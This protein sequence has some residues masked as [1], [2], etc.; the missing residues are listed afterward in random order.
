[1][2]LVET[3]KGNPRLKKWVHR[4]LVRSREARP[5]IWVKWFVN[6][7]VHQ[8]GRSTIIRW[9]ARM[10]VLPFNAF[11]LGDRSIIEDLCTVNNGSGPVEIGHDTMVGI[12]SVLIGPVQIGSKVIIAQHVVM[13]GLNHIYED[14]DQPIVDQ[15]VRTAPIIIEDE[16]WIGANA[17]I[18]AGVTIGKHAVV[19]GGA[20][21]TKNVPPY[22]I[23]AGNPAKIIKQYNTVSKQWERA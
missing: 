19:A 9:R 11:V 5:R 14:V 2:S 15:L 12:G 1:M 6:P 18:T 10:D 17:V 20:V 21:V 16:C 7:F 23:V 13:S 3:I 22:S 4:M 8:R